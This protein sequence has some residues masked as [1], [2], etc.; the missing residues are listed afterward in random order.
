M[1]EGGEKTEA[2]TQRRLDEAIKHGQ[3]A[4]SAEIQ[5][6]AVLLAGLVALRSVGPEVW[7]R[8]VI[9]F[10]S[11]LGHLHETTLTLDSLQD[12]AIKGVLFCTACVAPV[13]LTTMGAGL[14]AGALQSRFHTSSEVIEPNFDRVNPLNG[15]KRIFSPRAAVPALLGLF[16]M[17]IIASFSWKQVSAVL[18]DPIFF[19]AVDP[20]RVVT[21]LAD[22]SMS[23]SLRVVATLSVLAAADYLYQFWRTAKDLKMTKEEVKDE[24]KSSEGNPQVK[25]EM[26]KRRLKMKSF[27]R[28][29]TDVPRADVIVTN[30]THIAIAL[31]YDRNTMKAPQIIAKG[32]D[33]KAQQI[34]EVAKQHQIPILENKPLARMMYKYGKVD[35]EIP[36]QLYAAVAEILAYVYRINRYRYYMA[37]QNQP[38]PAAAATTARR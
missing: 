4:R 6:V 20:S 27:A 38:T 31:C 35:G 22:T 33:F 32:A 15:F 2:P 37:A 9:G 12:Y 11:T 16:K 30:P 34:R 14:L 28:Q 25:S 13:A 24:A 21:F 3:I 29:L 17:G 23:V 7:N 10:T 8:L 19:T 5:T 1:S 18:K 36:I 26:R